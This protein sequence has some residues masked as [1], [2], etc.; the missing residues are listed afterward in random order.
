MTKGYTSNTFSFHYKRKN[1]KIAHAYFWM[2][3][4]VSSVTLLLQ[5]QA[6]KTGAEEPLC[7]PALPPG[8]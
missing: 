6:N 4:T 7:S 2:I 3:K 8:I 5:F 1:I